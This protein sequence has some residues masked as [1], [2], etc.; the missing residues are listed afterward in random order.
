MPSMTTRTEHTRLGSK[1]PRLK[2]EDR[3]RPEVNGP[4]QDYAMASHGTV[5]LGVFCQQCIRFVTSKE[6]TLFSRMLE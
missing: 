5:F 3:A 1:K 4:K 2:R 6:Q